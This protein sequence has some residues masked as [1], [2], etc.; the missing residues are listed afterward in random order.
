MLLPIKNNLRGA[1][2]TYD[3]LVFWSWGSLTPQPSAGDGWP[4][5]AAFLSDWPH[6]W[7]EL[8]PRCGWPRSCRVG[9]GEETEIP[10]N[11]RQYRRAGRGK[12]S[13][14][15]GA[16]WDGNKEASCYSK[17]KTRQLL[18]TVFFCLFNYY[19]FSS[20]QKEVAPDFTSLDLSVT[21]FSNNSADLCSTFSFLTSAL[22]P[23]S[24]L[25]A[26]PFLVRPEMTMGSKGSSVPEIV[27]PSGPLYL[28]SS[29][30]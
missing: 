5:S 30:V 3:Q 2:K 25:S 14:C 17:K 16:D 24:H 20:F 10:E 9:R 11:T 27:M 19:Y 23:S 1:G 4:R 12:L 22:C 7:P 26:R 29:T 13:G 28:F 6:W 8:C 21:S 15:Q 18:L